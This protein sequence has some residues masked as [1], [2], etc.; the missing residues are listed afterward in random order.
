[1]S[2][3]PAAPPGR[4][5][6]KVC[7]VTRPEDAAAAEAAGVDA[8]GVVFATGSRRR[9]DLARGAEV[10]ADLGAFVARVG[11]FVAPRPDEV[12]AAVAALRLQVVQ[13]HDPPAPGG[14]GAGWAPDPRWWAD[15]RRRVAVVR[16]IA[17]TRDLD[18]AALARVDADLIL[19]DGPRAGSGERFD[20]RAATWLRRLR[21]WALAGGLN[22]GNVGEAIVRLRPWAVD[23]A[24]GVEAAPGIKD[25]AR[26]AAFVRAVR[27]AEAGDDHAAPSV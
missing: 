11:V 26:I 14:P 22:A 7:G 16:A 2:P 25:P 6:V 1:M 4:V 21:R 5:R 23:V 19:V 15:L 20:W 3:V 18:L 17:W 12:E 8:V 24:S 10:V 9:V 27:A 13:L